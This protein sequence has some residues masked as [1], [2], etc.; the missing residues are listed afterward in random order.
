[1]R[2]RSQDS[3][4]VEYTLKA[5]GRSVRL[6]TTQITASPEETQHD[7]NKRIAAIAKLPLNR[8]RVTLETSNTVIDKRVHA[9]A[10][11][12]M[13][14]LPGDET[15]LLVKDLGV[16]SSSTR[17]SNVANATGVFRSTNVVESGI[18]H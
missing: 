3:A 6:S 14:A 1:M 11:P 10:A 16:S 18:C 2:L 7:F 15:V 17:S 5:R 4:A 13:E 8:L 12:T 9:D